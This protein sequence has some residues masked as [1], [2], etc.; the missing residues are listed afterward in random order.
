MRKNELNKHLRPLWFPVFC[1]R[2]RKKKKLSM[3]YT[4]ASVKGVL[5]FVNICRYYPGSDS[6][7]FWL[8]LA[9]SLLIV[10]CGF[11]NKWIFVE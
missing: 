10:I 5:R 2:V 9:V 3:L 11:H 1:G 7:N 4:E 6:G 8:P